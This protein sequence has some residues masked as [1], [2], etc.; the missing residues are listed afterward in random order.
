[1]PPALA[2]LGRP[3][4]S[5][6]CR[7]GRGHLLPPRGPAGR[8]ALFCWTLS[9]ARAHTDWFYTKIRETTLTFTEKI[10][11]F[12]PSALDSES[13]LNVGGWFS[14]GCGPSAGW[15]W[16]EDGRA[17]ASAWP[18]A[19]QGQTPPSLLPAWPPSPRPRGSPSALTELGL[20]QAPP[21]APVGCGL[22]TALH[23]QTCL[24]ASTVGPCGAS[25]PATRRSFCARGHHDIHVPSVLGDVGTPMCPQG[26]GTLGQVSRS[27]GGPPQAQPA[28]CSP[29]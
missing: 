14:C 27:G 26:P 10:L 4:Q 20:L 23:M 28:A 29:R 24:A 15:G 5:P 1:M 25:R 12:L 11:S 17:A 21:Q 16:V 22:L 3:P 7:L 9:P 2:A 18:G 8:P 6:E 19:G 13:P